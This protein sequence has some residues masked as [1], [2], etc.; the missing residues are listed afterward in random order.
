MVKDTVWHEIITVPSG[1]EPLI[2][3]HRSTFDKLV[4]RHTLEAKVN[5]KAVAT[6]F[7]AFIDD[8]FV[9]FRPKLEGPF[10]IHL[11]S[12][13][14]IALVTAAVVD[15]STATP[16]YL[17]VP[18]ESE[19]NIEVG[20][21]VDIVVGGETYVA[22]VSKIIPPAAKMSPPERQVHEINAELLRIRSAMETGVNMPVDKG[23]EELR[24]G[25]WYLLLKHKATKHRS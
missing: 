6:N 1:K 2:E 7:K 25:Q 23:G 18:V 17:Q 20:E 16:E 15:E 3:K 9:Q 22:T 19:P 14:Y 24:R 10:T 12:E 5:W 8:L 4:T 13:R 11:T 21:D